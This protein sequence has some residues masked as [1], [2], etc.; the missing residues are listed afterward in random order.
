MVRRQAIKAVLA[1]KVPNA[2]FIICRPKFIY[3][4][5]TD[6]GPLDLSHPYQINAH[7]Q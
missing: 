5:M 3:C 2:H 4:T 6:W 1:K 7:V